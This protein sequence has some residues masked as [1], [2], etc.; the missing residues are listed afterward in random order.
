MHCTFS[1][2]ADREGTDLN[3]PLMWAA[4]KNPEYLLE[5]TADCELMPQLGQQ[6]S[7]HVCDRHHGVSPFSGTD[8]HARMRSL[9]VTGLVIA[10]VSLNVGVIGTAIEAVNLGYRVTVASD[11]VAAVPSDYGPAVLRNSIAAIAAVRTVEEIIAI[12]AA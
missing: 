1:L 4:H 11:A 3:I 7:D 6:T 5:H 8:L 2:R 10:G 9:A 12:W